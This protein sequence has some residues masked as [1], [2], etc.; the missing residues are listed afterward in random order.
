M[1]FF[2]PS[3]RSPIFLLIFP[4]TLAAGVYRERLRKKYNMDVCDF[5]SLRFVSIAA[6]EF[7]SGLFSCFRGPNAGSKALFHL[8]C[9]PVRLAANASAV[10]FMDFWFM[11]LMSVFFLPFVPILG[12]I[13]RL[14]MRTSFN[15]TSHPYSD[16]F[17][18]LCCYC[19]ALTQESELIDHGFS[20]L[21]RG[22]PFVY[23]GSRQDIVRM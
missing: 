7:P 23:V 21:Q 17:A 9:C 13:L 19:C 12:Y 2:I 11:L 4:C 6:T 10:G 5:G 20:A 15:M 1:F 18:W 14:H 3:F 22:S 8:C 16:F